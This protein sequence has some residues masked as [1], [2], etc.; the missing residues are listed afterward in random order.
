MGNILKKYK[1]GCVLCMNVKLKNGSV[2]HVKFDDAK[3]GS[4][5]FTDDEALQWG[6][7]HS[8]LFGK[9]FRLDG[10]TLLKTAGDDEGENSGEALP[11][12][13]GNFC[14]GD[15]SG[16]DE[17]D[18]DGT[19]GETIG[20]FC[21]LDESSGELKVVTVSGAE[22]AVE[23]LVDNF[24]VSRRGMKKMQNIIDVAKEHGVVFD[25]LN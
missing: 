19:N 5:L 25:G 4:V 11:K 7:E 3:N 9:S 24:G 8:C 22:D 6:L 10:D 12:M 20:N 16:G 23:Y 18:G 21:Q 15:E 2:K 1:A 14:Q 17:T 13:E